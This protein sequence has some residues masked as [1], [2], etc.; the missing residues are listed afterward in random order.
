ML[1]KFNRK[2][3][4]YVVSR[5]IGLAWYR[6]HFPGFSRSLYIYGDGIRDDDAFNNA[7][8]SLP[9]NPG[10]KVEALEGQFKVVA[11]ITPGSNAILEGQGPSTIFKVPATGVANTVDVISITA[12]RCAVRNIQIYGSDTVNIGRDG[13]SIDGGDYVAIE[14]VYVH[15]TRRHGIGFENADYGSVK[16]VIVSYVGNNNASGMGLGFFS[17]TNHCSVDQAWIHHCKEHGLRTWTD[18]TD[19]PSYHTFSNIHAYLNTQ[20]GIVF[21][22]SYYC[23]L[24]NFVSRNNIYH[25][26]HILDGRGT[27]LTNGHVE[28][29]MLNGMRIFDYDVSLVN[30]EAR[31]NGNSGV[32]IRYDTKCVDVRSVDNTGYGFELIDA[33]KAELFSPVATDTG[34]ATQT[35]GIYLGGSANNCLFVGGDV[36][37]NVTAGVRTVGA[38][39]RWIGVKG[40]VSEANVL[41]A[42]FAIDAVAVKTVN[43]THG[44]GYAPAVQDCQITVVEDTDVDDWGY[45]Y[46]KIELTNSTVVRCKVSVSN[47]SATGGATAKLALRA[48]KF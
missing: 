30:C 41:S 8:D 28:S 16:N 14:N 19:Y 37:G 23:R 1:I 46:V 33:A 3:K 48:L 17:K 10:G 43:I 7:F 25:G 15:H 5:Q 44:L 26:V 9:K 42:G 12:D 34:P 39:H 13:I 4:I 22:H 36:T 29:N 31:L 40:Y 18:D 6:R 2:K 20:C 38:G 35:Y 11:A 27:R 47:A 24:T 32:Y 45:D 21:Q